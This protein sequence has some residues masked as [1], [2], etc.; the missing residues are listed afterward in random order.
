MKINDIIRKHVPTNGAYL[1]EDTALK[2][3]ESLSEMFGVS[4]DEA[5]YVYLEEMDETSALNEAGVAGN[6]GAMLI[7]NPAVWAV[8]RTL[9]GILS[10]AKR[11]CGTFSI[12]NKRDVCIEEAHLDVLEKKKDLVNK[13][14]GDCTDKAGDDKSK[15]KK[16]KDNAQKTINDLDGK[17]VKRKEK[18]RVLKKKRHID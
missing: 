16:C 15:A 14:L 5:E 17:I 18:I 8:Y 12:S 4:Y 11:K 1:A 13:A 7:F 10:K 6:I 9:G 3:I 2:D